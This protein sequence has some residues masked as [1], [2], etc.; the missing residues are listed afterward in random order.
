MH[1]STSIATDWP[2]NNLTN[3]PRPADKSVYGVSQRSSSRE[4][5]MGAC[6]L[7]E[8]ERVVRWEPRTCLFFQGSSSCSIVWSER[9]ALVMIRYEPFIFDSTR[10]SRS[11]ALDFYWTIVFVNISRIILLFSHVVC[12]ELISISVMAFSGR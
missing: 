5:A 9:R 10:M 8:D 11:I 12:I 1:K 6:V 3:N 4:R 2:T 7:R